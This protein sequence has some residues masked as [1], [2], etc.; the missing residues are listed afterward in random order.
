MKTEGNIFISYAW[1]GVLEKK[2]WMRNNIISYL[3]WHYEVFWDR[4]SIPYGKTIDSTISK[5]LSKRPITIFCICDN[6]YLASSRKVNSG[7]YRELSMMDNLADDD[8]VNIVP[9]IIDANCK[10]SLPKLLSSRTYLDLSDH[11][12]RG[13]TLG[14]VILQVANGATQADITLCLAEQI[15]VANI[16]DRAESYFCDLPMTLIG[17]ASTH[18]VLN[19]L[20]KALT[21]P[22]WMWDSKEWGYMLGDEN[23]NETYCPSKGIWHWDHWSPSKGMR[24][25]GTAALAAFFPHRTDIDHIEAIEQGGAIIAKSF[26]AMTKKTESFIFD[27]NDIIV[28]LFANEHGVKVLDT[29][30]PPKA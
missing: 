8:K 27:A 11:H 14:P 5:A 9:I 16:R 26:F 1:G 17:N 15:R 4:D 23:E 24:A 20:R 30:L 3:S 7:L 6:E 28:S 10:N 29:L 21:P 12:R 22:Q 19:P 13:L 2:E 18:E 25:L